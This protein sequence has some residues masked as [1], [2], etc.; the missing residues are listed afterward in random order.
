MEAQGEAALPRA[1][2]YRWPGRLSPVPSV[3][4]AAVTEMVVFAARRARRPDETPVFLLGGVTGSVGGAAY[5][6][7]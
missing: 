6:S 3:P 1:G 7:G 2:A 5:R 4:V